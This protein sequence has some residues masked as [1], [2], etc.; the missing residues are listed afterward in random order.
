MPV[1]SGI[2]GAGDGVPIWPESNDA[3]ASTAAFATHEANDDASIE[4]P[5]VV[6]CAEA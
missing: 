5:T 2:G 3:A 6:S 4:S 1:C